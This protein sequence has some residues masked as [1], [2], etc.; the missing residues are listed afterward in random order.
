MSILIFNCKIKLSNVCTNFQCIFK[1]QFPSATAFFDYNDSCYVIPDCEAAIISPSSASVER[2]FST[3]THTMSTD[4]GNA[5]EDYVWCAGML[6]FNSDRRQREEKVKVT[7]IRSSA[8]NLCR[9]HSISTKS[10]RE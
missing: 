4:Q 2:L 7:T 10:N 5:L 8:F 9:P 3:I 6:R 1:F